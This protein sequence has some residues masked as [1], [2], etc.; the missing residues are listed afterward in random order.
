MEQTIMS[1]ATTIAKRACRVRQALATQMPV[2]AAELEA[3][4]LDLAI[5]ALELLEA[6][7]PAVLAPLVHR[8][9]ALVPPQP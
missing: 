1:R 8:L 2:T 9:Q 7:D 6:L 3:E 4:S 5:A